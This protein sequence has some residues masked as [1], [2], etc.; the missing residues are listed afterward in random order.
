MAFFF[1]RFYHRTKFT[2][3]RIF[4][5]R[6]CEQNPATFPIQLSGEG[7]QN[8]QLKICVDSVREQF[9]DGL[10]YSVTNWRVDIVQ[11]ARF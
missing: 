11:Y 8:L 10:N 7:H 5:I 6:T 2:T 1:Y 9:D 3:R 4:G